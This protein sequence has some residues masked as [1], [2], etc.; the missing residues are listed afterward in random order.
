MLRMKRT[1][2]VL[3]TAPD[4][5]KGGSVGCMSESSGLGNDSLRCLCFAAKRATSDDVGEFQL[6]A[7]LFMRTMV[8][9]MVQRP[10]VCGSF[11][12]RETCSL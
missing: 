3:I 4:L 5:S 11:Q 8:E 2:A 12:F 9:T 6:G 7:P 10:E 1:I